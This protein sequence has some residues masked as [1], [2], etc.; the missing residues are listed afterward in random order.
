MSNEEVPR[1]EGFL[2]FPEVALLAGVTKQLIHKAA[3]E[4]EEFDSLRAIG[5]KPVYVVAQSEV[6]EW[7]AR[8]E[9]K[10]QARLQ[11]QLNKTTDTVTPDSSA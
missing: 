2:T 9:A 6:D 4:N 7:L 8:R 5:S 1:L 10:K 3:L 11:R